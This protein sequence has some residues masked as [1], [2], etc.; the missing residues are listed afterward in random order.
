MFSPGL[1]PERQV[2]RGAD[3]Q[4]PDGCHREVTYI[5]DNS[6]MQPIWSI[7]IENSVTFCKM[8]WF[9]KWNIFYIEWYASFTKSIDY[10][11]SLG[12]QKNVRLSFGRSVCWSVCHNIKYPKREGSYTLRPLSYCQGGQKWLHLDARQLCQG[13][14]HHL[15]KV[16]NWML[17]R[18]KWPVDATHA[19]QI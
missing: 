14:R 12:I 18:T 6:F 9:L 19:A 5:S 15:H 2:H 16:N 8:H 11:R 7:R 3:A 17:T 4:L 13:S 10:T 1:V